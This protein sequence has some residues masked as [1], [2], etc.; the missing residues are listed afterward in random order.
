MPIP[1]KV[2]GKNG[3]VVS[4]IGYGCMGIS[5]F[6]AGSNVDADGAFKILDAALDLGVTFFDT[7]RIYGDNEDKIGQW[8]ASSPDKRSKVFLATKFGIHP[9]TFKPDGSPE[10][11]AESLDE[12]LRRLQTDYVDLFYL[13]RVDQNTPIEITVKAMA[14]AVKAGKVKYLGLSECSAATLR[15]AH[16]VHPITAVQIEYSPFSLEAE[17]NGL[18]DAAKELGVA[19][20]AYS[21]LSRGFLTGKYRSPDDFPEGDF[22]RTAP[23]FQAENFAANLK[24][25]DQMKEIAD[26]KGISTGQLTL[27][28]EIANDILPI[29][30]T[31]N[32]ERL[33]ENVESANVKLT[34]EE[35]AEMRAFVEN[36]DVKGD[37]YSASESGI[38]YADTPELK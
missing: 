1:S 35:I 36:A 9:E 11:V 28:W 34:S 38:L 18:I 13:H 20:V 30:G 8:L 10:Y 4:T 37:R 19:V 27:A 12:S 26:K 5:A 29:P 23:R 17:K 7:A 15:R 22:R 3:P 33:K 16:A 31:T 24:L 25:L 14:D 6:Y 2:L 32:P 21:P